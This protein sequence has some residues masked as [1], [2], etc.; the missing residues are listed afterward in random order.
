MR[1]YEVMTLDDQ[2]FENPFQNHPT[3]RWFF[4]SSIILLLMGVFLFLLGNKSTIDIQQHDT[5]YVLSIIHILLAFSLTLA[6]LG[7][8]YYLFSFILKLGLN[9]I[10]SKSHYY[11][12]SLSMAG[13]LIFILYL[14][15]KFASILKPS[16][17]IYNLISVNLLF[18]IGIFLIGQLLFLI[19]IVQSFFRKN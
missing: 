15:K 16:F 9:Q 5:Y 6:L 17:E 10:L 19:N 4:R 1:K 13:T 3:Y 18:F 12:S 8:F 7:S 14:E 11:F 2:E